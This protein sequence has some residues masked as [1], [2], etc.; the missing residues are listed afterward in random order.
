MFVGGFSYSL[1]LMHAPLLQIVW[2]YMLQ[3]LDLRPGV[4]LVALELVGIP[5]VVTAAY[6]F[7]RVFERPFV[8]ASRKRRPIGVTQPE[9]AEIAVVI[10]SPAL[11]PTD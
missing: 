1:Y 10:K 2:Q 11:V 5:L 8:N 6:L 3:P 9:R 7:Y 4:G